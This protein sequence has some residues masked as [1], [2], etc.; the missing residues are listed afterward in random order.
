MNSKVFSRSLCIVVTSLAILIGCKE[1]GRGTDANSTSSISILGVGDT[2][3]ASPGASLSAATAPTIFWGQSLAGLSYHVMIYNNDGITVTCAAQTFSASP[4]TLS[5]CN[6][7]SG[8]TYKASV[9][10]ALP[11]GNSLSA[12]NDKFLF[13]VAAA[14]SAKFA[15]VYDNS[16][17]VH[18]YAVGSD[19]TLSGS[20][21]MSVCSAIT[22]DNS[23]HFGFISCAINGNTDTQIKSFA[24]SGTTGALTLLDTYVISGSVGVNFEPTGRFIYYSNPDTS[25]GWLKV[26]S[27]TGVMTNGG[28]AISTPSCYQVNYTFDGLGRFAY[29]SCFGSGIAEFSLDQTT[30]APT[31]LGLASGNADVDFA[32][33]GGEASGK[34]I[35]ALGQY[36][37]TIATFA[38]N[39]S[40][41]VLTQ[42]GAAITPSLTDAPDWGFVS[43]NGAFLFTYNASTPA[44]TE[45]KIGSDGS[46]T[47]ITH[48][49]LAWGSYQPL[50][51][52]NSLNLAYM[53][54]DSGQVN[55]LNWN[56]T[57]GAMSLNQVL[58]PLSG[59]ASSVGVVAF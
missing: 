10:A 49:T 9:I 56:S 45:S 55:L 59:Q 11:G 54:N 51:F 47:E 7:V 31:Y 44:L 28:S 4:A 36:S 46:L 35:V 13:S 6:L 16:S 32:W 41:G 43:S 48:T 50:S 24:I 22:V 21:V 38:V 17:Q 2:T 19:G 29:L 20:G 1:D 33:V 25:L 30:G 14:P 58:D 8:T 12:I 52:L 40:T 34:Y 15:Y 39:Q 57:T 26:D 23:N 53:L 18:I 27:S 5:G 42:T 3:G 37:N